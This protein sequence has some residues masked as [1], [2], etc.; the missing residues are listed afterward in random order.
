MEL[1]KKADIESK[2]M[3]CHEQMATA[4]TIIHLAQACLEGLAFQYVRRRG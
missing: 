1:V 2:E 3:E 4:A